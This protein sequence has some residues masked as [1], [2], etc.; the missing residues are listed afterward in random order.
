[1]LSL[2]YWERINGCDVDFEWFTYQKVKPRYWREHGVNWQW[3]ESFRFGDEDDNEYEIFSEL[4]A[5]TWTN[6]I[7][8]GNVIAV[9]ILPR[10]LAKCRS[11]GNKLSFFLKFN[12]FATGKGLNLSPIKITALIF[13]FRNSTMNFPGWIFFENTRKNYGLKLVLLIVLVLKSKAF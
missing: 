5:L 3:I 13:Q 12:H 9:V 1:M 7:L 2:C 6:A 4:S 10:V 8:A 11:G